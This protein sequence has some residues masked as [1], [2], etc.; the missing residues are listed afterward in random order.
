MDVYARAVQ[1][2]RDH[3]LLAANDRVLLGV[4][5]GA[6]SVALL[7]V[8]SRLQALLRLRV[9]VVHVDHQL[10]AESADDARFVEAL[11]ARFEL[12]VTVIRRNVRQEAAAG[13]S[14][15]DAARRVR[16][17]AFQEVA[18]RQS[19]SR[20]ALAHT[21][22]DQA[23][24]VLLRLL[25]G[26]GLTGLSAIP[27]SRPLGEAMVIRPL[28]EI[29]REELLAYLTQHRLTFRTDVT[30]D[31][32]AFVRNRIRR[33]LLPMLERSYNPRIK[34]LLT[35]VAEQCRTDAGFLHASAQRQ[36]KRL[37][38]RRNG[39]LVIRRDAWLKQPKA[40]Q[41]QLI[42]LAIVQ[43]QG[44]LTGFEF[45]HWL[46]IEQLFQGRPAGTIIQLPGR[47]RLERTREHVLVGYT[48]LR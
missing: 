17:E 36:W 8:M 32:P 11:G 40:L 47:V 20:I 39:H 21:A 25:R 43:L 23:E 13:L 6:D 31:D 44:D 41:R 46:E 3:R 37:V 10:R 2:V 28:L 19:A 35:Q 4:S 42:R 9:S 38:K 30:N 48:G 15:E 1:F 26:A 34:V 7:H 45:R 18:R 5:G 12:P 22:D 14:P 27:V 16:Y 29:W 33:E 24:T